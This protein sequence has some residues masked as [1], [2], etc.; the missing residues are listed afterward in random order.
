ML[1]PEKSKDD[2][3][4]VLFIESK[5]DI[6]QNLNTELE[7]ELCKN[8][9]YSYCIKIGQLKNLKIFK[10]SSDGNIDYMYRK[11]ACARLGNI[12]NSYLDKEFGWTKIF[13]GR[14]I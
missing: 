3:F 12:K 8:F 14:I 9:H 7:K 6:S 1:T 10:V 11:N 5:S 4:Y 13:K 2:I